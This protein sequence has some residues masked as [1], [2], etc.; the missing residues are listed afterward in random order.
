MISPYVKPG[1]RTPEEIICEA[2][3]IRVDDLVVKTRKR[4]IVEARQFAM[5]YYRKTYPKMSLTKIGDKFGGKDHATVLHAMKT[6]EILYETD[7]NF[8]KKADIAYEMLE[9][10]NNY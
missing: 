9:K 8:R 3:D 1:I 4:E 2:F 7:K 6:V 10:I 5:N